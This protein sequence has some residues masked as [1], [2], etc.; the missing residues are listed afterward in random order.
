MPPRRSLIV[1]S[2]SRMNESMNCFTVGTSSIRPTTCPAVKMPP[3]TSPAVSACA[4]ARA[5]RQRQLAQRARQTYLASA[6]PGDEV[7]DVGELE[8]L[9]LL[10]L[11]AL[12]L[13]SDLVLEHAGRVVKLLPSPSLARLSIANA[14]ARAPASARA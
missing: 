13:G 6:V 10:V 11:D 8:V 4:S 12:H 2:A 1:D 7:G 9:A 3:S 14:A 5:S